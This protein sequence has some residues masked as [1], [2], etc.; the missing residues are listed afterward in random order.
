VGTYQLVGVK[1]ADS[2]VSIQQQKEGQISES[3]SG[4]NGCI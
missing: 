2:L 4:K 3:S 1:D